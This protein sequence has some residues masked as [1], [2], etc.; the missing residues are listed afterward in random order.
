MHIGIQGVMQVQKHVCIAMYIY[1]GLYAYTCIHVYACAIYTQNN[2]ADVQNCRRMKTK[3]S[4]K[5]DR[6]TPGNVG[7]RFGPLR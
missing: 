2:L 7:S 4:W 3:T 5:S 6:C 1:M